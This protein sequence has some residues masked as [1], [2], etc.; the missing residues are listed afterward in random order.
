MPFSI[1]ILNVRGNVIKHAG[2]KFSIEKWTK[3]RS[4]LCRDGKN[5]STATGSGLS[6]ARNAPL[7]V[8]IGSNAYSEAKANCKKPITIVISNS[9]FATYSSVTAN[10]DGPE[11]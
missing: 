5:S 1:P 11:A 10:G 7:S 9:Y 4:S 6:T 3:S 2:V 8:K